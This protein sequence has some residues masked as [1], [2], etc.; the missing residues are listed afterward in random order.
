[1]WQCLSSPSLSFRRVL[2]VAIVNGTHHMHKNLDIP[3][4]LLRVFGLDCY[5]MFPQNRVNRSEVISDHPAVFHPCFVAL[6]Y[7][8]VTFA[9]HVISCGQSERGCKDHA[10]VCLHVL[11]LSYLVFCDR[12]DASRALLKRGSYG[13]PG[14]V[15]ARDCAGYVSV[16]IRTVLESV[17]FLRSQ[18]ITGACVYKMLIIA[19]AVVLSPCRCCREVR[20]GGATRATRVCVHVLELA[21]FS[22]SL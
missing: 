1:M 11:A 17:L 3:D 19:P 14:R 6:S 4:F 22:V 12:F 15:S 16:A 20:R 7:N 9:L 21:M 5:I 10:A 13:P 18:R 2:G 8:S